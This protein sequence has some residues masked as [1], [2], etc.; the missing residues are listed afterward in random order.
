MAR[1]D[2]LSFRVRTMS[3]NGERPT[4]QTLLEKHVHPCLLVAHCQMGFTSQFP[5]GWEVQ[6][7][8]KS[9]TQ[10]RSDQL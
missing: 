2:S 3:W 5:T 9:R 8:T 10:T 4:D 1:M 6:T 7:E